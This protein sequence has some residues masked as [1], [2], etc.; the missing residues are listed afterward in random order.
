MSEYSKKT[1]TAAGCLADHKR[2]LLS[3][4]KIFDAYVG[5]NAIKPDLN[6][7]VMVTVNSVNSC[8]YC[9]GLHGQLAR[10]AGVDEQETLLKS[11]SEAACR[12]V[13]DHPAITFARRFAESNGRGEVS[14][15]AFADLVQS[16][17]KGRASSIRAL[18]WFLL[19]GSIGGNTIN[20]F[21][22]RL[23]GQ[24]KKTS[25]F[26]FE[27]LFF[28]YY[29]PLFAIIGAVNFILKFAPKVPAWFSAGFGVL[30]TVIASVWIIPLG[31]LSLLIPAK[32]RILA[33]N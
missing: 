4:P 15:N 33:A 7:S 32:P 17:G 10:M 30:L 31:L 11:D 25:S 22:S 29:G 21:I 27:L 6:E 12:A 23:R 24:A 14:E 16:E 13:V 26:F 9:E 28:I 2:V 3:I 8:P 1:W 20:A 18:S 19:W 5:P